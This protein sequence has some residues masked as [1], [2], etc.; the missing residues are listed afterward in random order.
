M[1]NSISFFL[2]AICGS[3]FTLF[4]WLVFIVLDMRSERKSRR[5]ADGN[6]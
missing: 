6:K 4:A 3:S 2:G 1:M 5:C